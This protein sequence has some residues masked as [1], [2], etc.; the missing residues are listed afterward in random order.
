MVFAPNSDSRHI[1]DGDVLFATAWHTVTSVLD[2]PP[3]KGEKCY[4]I[5]HYETW[6]GPKSLV[7]ETW[8]APLHKAV[9]SKWLL[10]LGK[11]LGAQNICHIP[12]AVDHQIYRLTRPIEQ[13]KRQVAMM[14]SYVGF[15]AS[16]DGIKALQIAKS[17][18]ADLRVVL[19]G[20][21][22]A[23]SI[24]P[25]WMTYLLDPPQQNIVDAFNRSSIVLSP[26]IAEGFGLPLAEGAACGCAMVS[27]DSGGVRDFI[28]DGET[29]LLSPP[30]NPEALA[31]NLCRLLADDDLRIR[32]A[33][34]GRDF[35][36]RFNWERSTD[37]LE[38]FMTCALKQNSVA[39][40]LPDRLPTP[41][42]MEIP[43]METN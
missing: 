40:Q 20:I 3:E 35:I 28:I 10:E 1:P 42:S 8:R 24:V 32:F 39:R 7:D 16:E 31:R 18:F 25:D 27:T 34:A 6:Q 22:R 14:F 30:S 23:R 26:S 36:G 12:A 9:V 29:G 38:E 5:Q 21:N 15:K 37:L 33:Q 11:A 19:F 17:Q 41:K 4:L 2:C 13:R 43:A